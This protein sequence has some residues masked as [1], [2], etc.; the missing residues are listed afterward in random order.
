MKLTFEITDEIIKE[1]I[2]KLRDKCHNLT[3]LFNTWILELEL[4]I[5]D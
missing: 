3:E 1:K 4:E 2:C 5:K